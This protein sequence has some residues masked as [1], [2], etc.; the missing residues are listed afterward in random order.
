VPPGT[1]TKR[2]SQTQNNEP[3]NKPTQIPGQVD[4]NRKQNG[5]NVRTK[6]VTTTAEK[7]P[8]TTNNFV[9]QTPVG[10]STSPPNTYHAG[11]VQHSNIAVR[12]PEV[13]KFS[14]NST[15]NY[16]QSPQPNRQ[17]ASVYHAPVTT[18]QAYHAPVSTYHPPAS[19]YHPPAY[20]PAANAYHAPANAGHPPASQSHPNNGGNRGGG[21]D[22]KK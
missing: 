13:Q 4:P 2:F 9:Q 20:H 6:A 22:K 11:T 15:S 17:N 10:Q 8:T 12:K 3:L 16:V 18:T 7:H 14:Q 21:K 19:T 1:V 5:P